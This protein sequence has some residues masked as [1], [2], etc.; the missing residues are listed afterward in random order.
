MNLCAGGG[1]ASGSSTLES[2]MDRIAFRGLPKVVD[3]TSQ[4]K[5]ADQ[6]RPLTMQPG[7]SG[8]KLQIFP[9]LELHTG[10]LCCLRKQDGRQRR[11]ACLA[12]GHFKAC[13]TAEEHEVLQ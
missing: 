7:A 2:L 5:L 6:V 9:Q 13:G 8:C 10:R 11:M 3:L 12:T 4:R 1:G